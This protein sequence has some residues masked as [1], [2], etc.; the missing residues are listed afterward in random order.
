M[1]YRGKVLPNIYFNACMIVIRQNS[2]AGAQI[3]TG[4]M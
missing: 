1:S 3:L 4:K 2:K